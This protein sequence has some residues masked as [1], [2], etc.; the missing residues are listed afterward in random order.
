MA[1]LNINKTGILTG[2]SILLGVGTLVVNAISKKDEEA[3]IAEKA[4]K[5]VMEQNQK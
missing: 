4:A 3:K 1:K 2:A 5:I